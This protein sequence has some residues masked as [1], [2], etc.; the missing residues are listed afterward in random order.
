MVFAGDYFE[1]IVFPRRCFRAWR[2]L[3]AKAAHD[4]QQREEAEMRIFEQNKSRQVRTRRL[5]RAFGRWRLYFA[6]ILKERME[7]YEA[8]YLLMPTTRGLNSGAV[9]KTFLSQHLNDS[10]END[11]QEQEQELMYFHKH[12]KK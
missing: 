1:K 7:R 8:R 10:F 5:V 3:A 11:E 2:K 4:R 9:G 6:R 12:D